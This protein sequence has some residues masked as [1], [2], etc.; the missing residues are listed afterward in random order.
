M[1]CSI[2][3]QNSDININISEDETI[4]KIKIS[5]DCGEPNWFEQSIDIDG[6]RGEPTFENVKKPKGQIL[7]TVYIGNDDGDEIIYET[8]IKKIDGGNWHVCD[9]QG[10]YRPGGSMGCNPETGICGL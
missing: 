5:F 7:I 2:Q 6:T 1:P 4:E 8:F 10:D 3:Y 9:I